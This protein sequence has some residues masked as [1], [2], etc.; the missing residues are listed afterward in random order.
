MNQIKDQ[1]VTMSCRITIQSLVRDFI[2]NE[3]TGSC[4]RGSIVACNLTKWQYFQF[5]T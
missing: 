5:V 2:I 1:A 3:K 4:S